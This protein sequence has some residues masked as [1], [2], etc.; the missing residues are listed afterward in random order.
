MRILINVRIAHVPFSL[1]LI[2][3]PPRE[4]GS[5]FFE[6]FT[7]SDR[8]HYRRASHRLAGECS[9][10]LSSGRVYQ[11]QSFQSHRLFMKTGVPTASYAAGLCIHYSFIKDRTGR[12][13]RPRTAPAFSESRAKENPSAVS[14]VY[15]DTS[16]RP[17]KNRVDN[18]LRTKRKRGRF[19]PW[20]TLGSLRVPRDEY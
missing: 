7:L 5:E 1:F 15:R 11:N 9:V 12:I 6:R 14:L 8:A 2:P 10:F 20:L 4:E 16:S 13:L 18:P 17:C 19:R 3:S